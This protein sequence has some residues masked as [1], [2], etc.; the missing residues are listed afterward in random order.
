M[1]KLLLTSLLASAILVVSAQNLDKIKD[2]LKAKKLPEAKTQ[3]DQFL[4]NEKNAKNAE[5]WYTKAKI[6]GEIAQDASLAA[7]TPDARWTS[8]EALKQYVTLDDKMLSL[9]IDNYKPI[10]DVYQGYFK[11]GAD[12]YNASR[13]E[14]AFGNFKNCLA[15]SEYMYSKK[16]SN[17]AL[18]TTVIL[19]SGISAE[20]SNKRDEAAFFY[21]KLADAKVSGEGM[22]EIYKWLVDHYYNQKKD[23][24]SA[25]KYLAL[26]KEVYPKDTFWAAYELDMARDNGNKP[27]LFKKYES[28][29]ASDPTNY[30]VRY[31]YAVE[32]YQEGY[33]A[34]IAARPANSAELIAKA[35]ENLKKVIEAKPDYAAAY[36]VLGQIQYNQG[37]DLNNQNKLIKPAGG[38]KLTP[39]ELKKKEEYRTQIATKFDAAV[40]YFEKVDQLLGSQGKLKMEEKGYLKDAYDLLIT[41]Y[42]NKG[43]KDKL[44]VYEEKFN[45][46]DKVH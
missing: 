1:K 34:D 46:V 16:W 18:D 5:G 26:G 7:S 38:K 28:V 21:G 43:N 12:D 13:F 10:M 39:E 15:V 33:K 17:V 42:D 45:N 8:F 40:P 27:E 30:S 11:A 36:L 22:V 23:V 37:V 41:I 25:E 31:N 6:Y 2:N 29:L 20:K 24:A 35:D 4:A 14:P 32:L 44:K 9:Q 19:Y 3:I